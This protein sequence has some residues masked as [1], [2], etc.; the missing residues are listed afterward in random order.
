[1]PVDQGDGFLAEDRDRLPWLEPAE[2]NERIETVPVQK[3]IA[4]IGLGLALLAVIVGGGWWLKDSMNSSAPGGDAAL[5]SAPGP[6]KIPADDEAAKKY[7]TDGKTFAG[8]GDSAYADSGSTNAAGRIDASKAPEMP[9]IEAVRAET[10]KPAPKPVATPKAGEKAP[11]PAPVVEASGPTLSGARVQIGA[12]NS[13]AIAEEAW[14]R[15]NKR[16]DELAGTKH[17]IE[18]VTLGGRTLHR[19][20][21]GASDRASA[22]A[23]CGRLRVAG[24]NC[25][26]V[27]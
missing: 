10:P 23:L 4:L 3:V 12:Y 11:A 15:L 1:M 5:I 9:L 16:F 17:A 6:Y 2:P 14:K 27:P 7:D 20:R 13:K 8:E 22:N 26:V 18:P 25:W 21:I 24:E 19:L